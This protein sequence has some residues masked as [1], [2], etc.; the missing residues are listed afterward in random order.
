MSLSITFPR[1]N[2]FV[3]ECPKLIRRELEFVDMS[4]ASWELEMNSPDA[5]RMN[6][7]KGLQFILIAIIITYGEG[8]TSQTVKIVNH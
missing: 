7:S 1:V 6:V 3:L 4:S 8:M 5:Y 2:K